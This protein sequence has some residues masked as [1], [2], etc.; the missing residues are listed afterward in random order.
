M[1]N[2]TI[3]IPHKDNSDLLQYCLDSI[4]IR[5]D[6]QVI[7]IDDNSDACKV[8]FDNFPKW[9]G[10]NY[11]FY[12]TKDGKGAGYCRNIGLEHAQGKWVLFVDADDY[13]LPC[14]SKFFDKCVDSKADVIYFRPKSVLLRDR[15]IL[16]KR[17]VTYN[18][19]IDEYHITGDENNLRVRFL[20]PWSKFVKRDLVEEHKIRF[21]EIRYSNDNFF[22]VAIGCYAKKIEVRDEIYYV[23]TES[24]DSLTSNFLGKPGE[25]ECRGGAFIR[26]S[27]LAS[28]LGY[29]IN[30]DDAI[31]FMRLLIRKNDFM[32]RR[33][34]DLV[35]K[36]FGY[37]ELHLLQITFHG[38][39]WSRRYKNYVYSEFIARRS[40]SSKTE[41]NERK[42]I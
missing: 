29:K 31:F 32:Y 39:K 34:F 9:K 23:I 30:Q 42:A 15:E 22:S 21:E 3:I 8:D 19:L 40:V 24:T 27:S 13:V 25:L 41:T 28:S 36:N 7:V 20:P 14:I 5:N 10:I 12:L 33:L 11:E 35:K 38:Y 6:V 37:T 26:A 18:K 2:Y 16:S 17:G 4:P 1:I